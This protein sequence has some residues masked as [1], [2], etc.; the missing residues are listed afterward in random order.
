MDLAED[1]EYFGVVAKHHRFAEMYYEHKRHK[2]YKMV[3][4][5]PNAH[6]STCGEDQTHLALGGIEE[7]GA[8]RTCS[9]FL[10]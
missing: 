1:E 2:L 5:K 10:F 7:S 9:W 4:E 3:R 6:G 8:Q